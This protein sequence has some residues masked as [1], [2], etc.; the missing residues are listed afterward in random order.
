MKRTDW[1]SKEQ[2]KLIE[3]EFSIEAKDYIQELLKRAVNFCGTI[4]DI[5]ELE[6]K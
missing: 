2:Y 3:T 4:D 5:D 1:Y 6:R